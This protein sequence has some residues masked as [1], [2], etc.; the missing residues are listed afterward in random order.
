MHNL[1][2][3]PHEYDQ[4]CESAHRVWVPDALVPG[5]WYGLINV[6]IPDG[7]EE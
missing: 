4:H 7:T 5:D 1:S 3:T 2:G 6:Q